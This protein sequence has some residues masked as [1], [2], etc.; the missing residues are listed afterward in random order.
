MNKLLFL[1]VHQPAIEH[2]GEIQYQGG[3]KNILSALKTTETMLLLNRD[4][5]IRAGSRKRVLL[6]TD[7][8][9][10][11][12]PN[13][14]ATLQRMTW[15]AI[16]IRTLGPEVFLVAVG[17]RVPRIEELLVIPSSTDTH[18]YRVSNMTAFKQI[19]D[20]IPVHIFYQDYFDRES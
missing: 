16:K 11:R 13:D 8:P 3:K 12:N 15:T 5:G 2:I 20:G 7:G 18:F 17:H 9:S 4:S 6:V 14:T 19:V 1:V 10:E